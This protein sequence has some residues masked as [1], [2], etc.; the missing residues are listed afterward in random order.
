MAAEK[1]FLAKLIFTGHEWLSNQEVTLSN[2]R[3]VSIEPYQNSYPEIDLLIP[4]FIDLQVYGAA[5]HLF[6]AFPSWETLELMYQEFSKEGTHFFLPTIAT[7]NPSTIESGIKAVKDYWEKGGK[8]C[9]GLHLEGPW[10]NPE[11]RGAHDAQFIK[12]PSLKDVEQLLLQGNDII[13]MITLAP[14][15]CTQEI[16]HFL[17]NAKVLLSAGHSMATFEQSNHAFSNG[18][19]LVTHLFNAMS[20][21]QH[22]APGL[23]GAT[24]SHNSVMASIIPDGYHVDWSVIKLSYQVMGNRLFTITDAVTSCDKGPYQH[25]LNNDH[26]V[27]NGVLSGSALTMLR[28]FNNLI[29]KAGFSTQDAVALCISNPARVFNGVPF[30]G[31]SAVG[32]DMPCIPLVHRA[33]GYE[34]IN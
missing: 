24:F 8:G 26:Y 16:L 9:L 18:V 5:S 14:E 19:S 31:T 21:L 11:K 3:L 23:V 2:N 22:R 17:V 6:S 25:T 7:N 29:F 12:V 15:V 20:P 30:L 27:A 32:I 34:V 28:A 10:I 33:Q 1:R 4:S 13:K